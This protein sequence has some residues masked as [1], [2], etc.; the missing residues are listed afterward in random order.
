[1]SRVGAEEARR[2][3]TSS[4]RVMEKETGRKITLL[5]YPNGR[6]ED[7]TEETVRLAKEAGYEAAFTTLFKNNK[8]R[9]DLFHLGRYRPWETHVPTFALRLACYRAM[10]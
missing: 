7:F 1:L 9:E 8:P 4:K 3:L 6:S 5:A 10:A 2:E